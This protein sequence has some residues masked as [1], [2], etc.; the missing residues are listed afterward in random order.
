LT[1]AR[2]ARTLHPPGEAKLSRRLEGILLAVVV[3]AIAVAARQM[4]G[5]SIGP[6]PWFVVPFVAVLLA[7]WAGGV[8]TGLTAVAVTVVGGLLVPWPETAPLDPRVVQARL[9]VELL[10]GLAAMLIGLV[11]RRLGAAEQT[12]RMRAAIASREAAGSGTRLSVLLEA[13]DRLHRTASSLQGADDLSRWALRLADAREVR[14][15]LQEHGTGRLLTMASTTRDGGPATD[16]EAGSE[17][18]PT[19]V[20]EALRTGTPTSADGVL[21]IP[22]TTGAG[23]AGVIEVHGAEISPDDA[24]GRLVSLVALGRLSGARLERQ[25]VTED[26]D[27]AVA[28]SASAWKRVGHLQRLSAALAT[29]VTLDAIGEAVIRETVDALQARV[30]LFYVAAAGGQLELAY[31]L[32]YPQGLASRD[33]RIAVSEPNPAA[34]AVRTGGVVTVESPGAWRRRYPGTSDVLGMTGTRSVIAVPLVG[35]ART[36]G[37]I[38]VHA[39]D[40]GRP[41]SEDLG[42]MLV[43]AQQ[44]VSAL[45]RATLY[46]DEREARR[47][48]EAFIGVVSHELRTPITTIFAGSK[49]LTRERGMTELGREL[50]GDIEA[51]ADRLFRLV[52]D[53]LVLTRLERG[54]LPVGEEPVHVT[55]IVERVVASERVRWPAT[56]FRL[57]PERVVHLARGE[58]TYVEQVIRNLLTNAAKYGAPGGLVDIVLARDRDAIVVRILDEGPGIHTEE[59]SQLFDLY[60]RSPS[61]AATA[62]GAG[63][64]LYVCR[65]LID[66]MGG[67]IW[68]RR[69]P[70]TGSEFGFSLEAYPVDDEVIPGVGRDDREPGEAAPEDEPTTAEVDPVGAAPGEPVA[71][72]PAGGLD[73]TERRE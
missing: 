8:P 9:F 14:V 31:Q 43:A 64:G 48:Q 67:R 3:A 22:M 37:A 54:H 6:S 73:R 55:R 63:I 19:I 70:D 68:A 58:E 30:G 26:R 20:R 44:G 46:A 66:A 71:A 29:A 57:P 52:E 35:A 2:K 47:V 42:L 45:E 56:R 32:G 21:A 62:A 34:D 7:T 4:L 16:D 12:S 51:E 38:V 49:L 36:L 23:T 1:A 41:S 28:S 72:V 11:I 53:L 5:A 17:D 13:V 15:H 60:Y 24:D 50:A 59:A 40:E 69:R 33:A 39:A 27:R 65:R 18:V 61:T 10:F 25:R